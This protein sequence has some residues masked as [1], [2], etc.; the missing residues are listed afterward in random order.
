MTIPDDVYKQIVSIAKASDQRIS[1]V[2]T[3]TLRRRLS[4][5]PPPANPKK[6]GKFPFVTFPATGHKIDPAAIRR[7]I[8]EEPFD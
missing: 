2:V 6:D 8:E 1:E 7:A 4:P 3:E 5:P